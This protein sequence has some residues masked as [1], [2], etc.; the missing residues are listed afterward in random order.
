VPGSLPARV[1]APVHAPSPIP[2]RP[3][4]PHI[5]PTDTADLALNPPLGQAHYAPAPHHI[6]TKHY[7]PS[8]QGQHT[9]AP[10]LSKRL[11][12][13]IHCCVCVHVPLGRVVR[14][15]PRR[16]TPAMPSQHYPDPPAT[17]NSHSPTDTNTQTHKSEQHNQAPHTNHAHVLY[18][19]EK[20]RPISTPPIKS[21]F[22]TTG[23]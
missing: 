4:T 13:Y 22:S 17:D 16:Q 3:L 2:R 20:C 10:Q 15:T 9:G 11:I 18:L 23:V 1:T 8:T 6:Y 21:M 7:Q 5:P 19:D 14:G 12:V